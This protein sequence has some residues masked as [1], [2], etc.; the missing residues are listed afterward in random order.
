MTTARGRN[1]GGNAPMS[2]N[3]FA[4]FGLM[5]AALAAVAAT[6]PAAQADEYNKSYTVTG[7]AQ[8]HVDTNDGA[9]RVMT[10]PAPSPS[11]FTSNTRASRSTGIS[12][13]SR[14]KMAI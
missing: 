2:L 12:A 5:F 14:I 9:V 10:V 8:V 11:S 3:R 13:S 4:K 6:A 7:R 1:H